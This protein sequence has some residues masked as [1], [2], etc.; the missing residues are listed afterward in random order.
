MDFLSNITFRKKQRKSQSPTIKKPELDDS[1]ISTDNSILDGTTS[2]LPC[3]MVDEN[4]QL[5][6]LKNEIENLKKELAKA[7]GAIKQLAL[8]NSELRST[9]SDMNIKYEE[10]IRKPCP[11]K[12]T[13]QSIPNEAHLPNIQATTT[14]SAAPPQVKQPK[15]LCISSSCQEIKEQNTL[16]I[17]EL[18]KMCIISSNKNNKILQIAEN[19]V[20]NFTFCHY[21]YPN[22]DVIKLI[23]NISSK[24]TDFTENDYCVIM[25]GKEDF[26]KTINYH[27]LIA[28][29]RSTLQTLKHTNII[30]CTP[31]YRYHGY[32]V[33]YNSRVEAFNN[34]LC[35]DNDTFK[36]AIVMD[37]NLKLSCNHSM[38]SVNKGTLNNNGMRNIFKNLNILIKKNETNSKQ[39]NLN[40][41]SEDTQNIFFRE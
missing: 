7:Q 32:S 21:I 36:Y 11:A 8:E 17:K 37:S 2:S 31:T 29:I 33:L 24:I 18:N 28:H 6:E 20:Q 38:F 30:I 22:C 1:N 41:V 40:K 3:M 5:R 26:V 39:N 14:P 27:N 13:T 34:M 25:I 35:N 4:L 23:D 10:A 15:P 19:T 16:S 12:Q 9:V